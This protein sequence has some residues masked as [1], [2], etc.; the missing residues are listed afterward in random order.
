ML[1][2]SLLRCALEITRRHL[3]DNHL[4]T[5]LRFS[6][7]NPSSFV[8]YSFHRETCPVR[9]AVNSI[10]QTQIGS[11]TCQTSQQYCGM[12]EW[13]RDGVQRSA[14]PPPHPPARGR[15]SGAAPSARDAPPPPPARNTRKEQSPAGGA[16]FQGNREAETGAESPVKL[17]ARLERRD[18]QNCTS[19]H[20]TQG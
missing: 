10:Y 8:S 2:E 15:I 16:A 11:N 13:A 7:V 17:R 14:P 4:F 9:D 5:A 20:C 19:R 1:S 12:R 18:V 6:A 3:L